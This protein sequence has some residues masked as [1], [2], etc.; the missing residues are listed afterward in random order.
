MP[1]K[2]YLIKTLFF[3]YREEILILC[4]LLNILQAIFRRTFAAV[5]QTNVYTYIIFFPLLK[6]VPYGT[7]AR[8]KL[9]FQAKDRRIT[10]Y[11]RSIAFI[12]FSEFFRNVSDFFEGSAWISQVIILNFSGR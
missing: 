6:K 10:P 7:V 3:R 12:L 5:P 8:A 2:S 11:T 1:P 4:T 9:D